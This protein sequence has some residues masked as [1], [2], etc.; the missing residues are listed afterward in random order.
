MAVVGKFRA[1]EGLVAL[2]LS[3]LTVLVLQV[4]LIR[5]SVTR[6]VFATRPRFETR[7]WLRVSLSLMLVT[8]FLVLLGQADI[9]MVGAMLGPREAGIYAAAAKTATLV[10]FFLMAMNAVAAPMIA[11]FWAKR[12]ITSLR[13]MVR[14][15]TRWV[16]LPSLVLTVV[17]V[18]FGHEVLTLFGPQFRIGYFPLVVLTIG[19]LVN[20]SVGPVGY[21]M[22]LTGYHG[23]S[24]RVYAVTAALNVMMNGLLIPE[25]G[26][27]GAAVATSCAMITWN[28]WLYV[29]VQRHLRLGPFVFGL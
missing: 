11:S 8:G 19:W 23:S 27:R 9:L 4:P 18:I 1:F 14:T 24:V 28:V 17:L 20:C 15:A 29:L 2:G 16:L 21:L 13:K 3:F 25:F 5:Q 26:I 7:S 6:G 22:N 12:D 10:G